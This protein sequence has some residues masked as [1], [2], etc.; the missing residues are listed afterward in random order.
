MLVFV[1]LTAPLLYLHDELARTYGAEHVALVYGDTTKA[2]RDAIFMEFQQPGSQLDI[3]VANPGTLSHGLTLTEA[4]T[5]IWYAPTHSNETYQQANGRI[6]RPG[7]T[8]NTLV[9]NIEG[10]QTERDV[11]DSLQGKQRLQDVVL[12]IVQEHREFV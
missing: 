5:I 7:Q 4:N 2:K 1:P 11:Y 3:I 10:S 6:V 9:V 8:R 12:K